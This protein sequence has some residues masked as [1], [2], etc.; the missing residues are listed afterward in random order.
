MIIKLQS[1][2]SERLGE[3]E[4]SEGGW[5]SLGRGNRIDFAGELRKDKDGR[6]GIR[7]GGNRKSR[8]GLH[9]GIRWKRCS[10]GR[11]WGTFMCVEG[12]GIG[13]LV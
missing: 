3:N 7:C 8:W 6:G 13:N 9:P 2:D 11:N 10:V 12:A 4:S 5:I 1:I